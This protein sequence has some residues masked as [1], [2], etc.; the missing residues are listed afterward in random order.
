MLLNA[1]RCNYMYG[2]ILETH[3]IAFSAPTEAGR[4]FAAKYTGT[5]QFMIYTSWSIITVTYLLFN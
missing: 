2:H 1:M 3:E 4:T 5:E